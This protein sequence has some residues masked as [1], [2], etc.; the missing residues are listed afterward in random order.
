MVDNSS[1]YKKYIKYKNKYLQYKHIL[2]GGYMQ[3]QL[4]VIILASHQNAIGE[5]LNMLV[6]NYATTRKKLKN[7]AC[8]EIAKFISNGVAIVTVQMIHEGELDPRDKN[9]DPRMYFTINEFNS[10]GYTFK[11]EHTNKI[12]DNVRIL[13]IRHGNGPHNAKSGVFGAF[14]KLNNSDIYTDPLLT[15]LGINQAE[16]ASQLVINTILSWRVPCTVFLCSSRLKRAIQTAGIIGFHILQQV[17]QNPN[18]VIRD[19]VVIVPGVE[20]IVDKVGN[21]DIY[22]L[23]P[24]NRSICPIDYGVQK[25]CNNLY[26]TTTKTIPKTILNI[27]F[28]STNGYDEYILVDFTYI[29]KYK[30]T[31]F[32]FSLR[33]NTAF[34]VLGNIVK[35]SQIQ[36]PYPQ[37]YAQQSY[38]QQPHPQ[39]SQLTQQPYPQAY[40]QQSYVQQPQLTQ[41]PQIQQPY[42]QIRQPQQPYQQTQSQYIT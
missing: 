4:S 21:T 27:I 23:N 25:N 31:I 37:S 33:I 20:E 8:L 18:I 29:S 41:Q 32:P 12:E 40:A 34:I 10:L 36:Q 17:A 9:K 35:Q 39:I 14:I 19:T 1:Y 38:V 7:C 2:N 26:I 5:M 11:L 16:R 28:E 24:E 13:L 15:S 6:N 42:Q 22:G 3:Q 30:K